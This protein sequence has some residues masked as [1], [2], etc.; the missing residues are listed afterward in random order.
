[1]EAVSQTFNTKNHLFPKNTILT[2]YHSYSHSV[3]PLKL[4][5]FE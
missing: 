3:S 1:M 4:A 5:T 2:H